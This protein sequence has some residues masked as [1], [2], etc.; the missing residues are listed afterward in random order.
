MKITGYDLRDAISGWQLKRD[1]ATKAFDGSLYKFPDENKE[2]PNEVVASIEAAELIIAK[3]QTAQM[4]YN[5]KVQLKLPGGT[6]SLA[7]AI[8]RVGGLG[9]I[10]KMWKSAASPKKRSYLDLDEVPTRDDGRI[11]AERQLNTKEVIEQASKV[12]KLAG[13]FRS[14][15]AVG[16][17]TE[18]DIDLD[19]SL[20][21]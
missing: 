2:T 21:E 20:F 4:E 3:L 7:E 8:K 18:V 11:V 10:E 12:G 13:K 19:P 15:I 14:A 17:A 6:L 16:N 5:L 1:A 9:R